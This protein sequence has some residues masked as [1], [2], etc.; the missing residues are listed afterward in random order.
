[1]GKIKILFLE[2]YTSHNEYYT[3][4]AVAKYFTMYTHDIDP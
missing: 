1:M 2:L 3:N 4:F